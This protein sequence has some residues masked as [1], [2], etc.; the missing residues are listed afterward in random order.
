MRDLPIHARPFGYF[1]HHQGRGHA[2]RAAAILNALPPSRPVTVFCARADIFPPLP[3]QARV[4]TIP[5]FFER[6]GDECDM[7]GIATPD[8]LH[9]APLGWPGIRQAMAQIAL[10][11]AEADPALMICDVSAE[12][13]Q[14]ARICS[15][16]HVKVLQHGERTDPGHQAAYAG[17]AGLLAPFAAALAQPD[18]Q[19]FAGKTHFAPG[20]GVPPA[21][22]ESKAAARQAL[23][24]PGDAKVALVVSGGGGSG[25]AAAPLGVAARAFPDWHWL[26]I[27]PVQAD[28]HATQGANLRALGWVADPA[29]YI[30]AT[31]LVIS[32]TGNTTCA[33]V[34]AAGRP[35]IVVPEWRYFDEQRLKAEALARAGAALHLPHLPSSAHAW[36]AAVT[37]ALTAHDPDAQAALVGAAPATGAAAWLEALADDLWGAHPVQPRPLAHLTQGAPA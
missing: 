17:A 32:S 28:W 22:P 9:C 31:D 8:T 3:R 24:L 12:I 34:L 26:S 21:A 7:D 30:A 5:S 20:L 11:F 6:T 33:G 4:V 35:W 14:L 1:V 18:W 2:E 19:P 16:P 37:A 36:R 13:A 10:W 15:V 23:G 25:F 29:R 27:G